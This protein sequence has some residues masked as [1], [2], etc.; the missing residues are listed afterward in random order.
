MLCYVSSRAVD[1]HQ[2]CSGGLI[3]GKALL[4]R[5]LVDPSPNFYRGGG[6]NSAKFGVVLNITQI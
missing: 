3:V 2:M 4:S 6:S 1:R 5:D